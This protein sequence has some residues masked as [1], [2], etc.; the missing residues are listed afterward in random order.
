MSN[1]KQK[2]GRWG[3][4]RAAQYLL[5]RGYEIVARNLRNEYGELDLIA[6]NHGE[7]I[8]VEVKARRSVQFGLP[9]EAI[10]PAKQKH[11]LD[12]VQAYL[13]EHAQF[14]GDWRVDVIAIRRIKG[15]SPEISHFENAFS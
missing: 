3:E 9:E 12:A 10:T 7:M 1:Q 5:S 6:M 11:N 14:E 15:Q 13:Q 4:E 2:F 8:F